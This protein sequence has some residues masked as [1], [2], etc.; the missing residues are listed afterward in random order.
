MRRP[1]ENRLATKADGAREDHLPPKLLV[2][3]ICYRRSGRCPL[4]LRYI[5]PFE[6]V[7]RR[8]TDRLKIDEKELGRSLL[9]FFYAAADNHRICLPRAGSG[10]ALTAKEM[11]DALISASSRK[12]ELDWRSTPDGR[13]PARG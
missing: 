12:S 6:C 2:L 7:R 4:F 5:W 3:R 13:A 8:V 1:I 11:M 10:L 9:L